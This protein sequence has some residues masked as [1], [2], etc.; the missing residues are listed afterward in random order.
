MVTMRRGM[1]SRCAME[2]AATASV[3]EI[4]TPNTKAAAHGSVGT[5]AWATQLNFMCSS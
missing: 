5:I 4:M 1:L 3:G 2:V